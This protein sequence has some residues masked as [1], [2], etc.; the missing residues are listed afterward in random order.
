[1]GTLPV[2]P[3]DPMSPGTARTTPTLGCTLTKRP[4]SSSSPSR[5]ARVL[6]SPTPAIVC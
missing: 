2:L 4:S 5:R 6:P 3:V 1:P